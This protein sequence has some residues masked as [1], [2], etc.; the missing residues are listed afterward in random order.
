EPRD[1]EKYARELGLDMAKFKTEWESEA[2]ADRVS[3]DRKQGDALSLS[4]TP[5]IYINGR[6]FE[7][8]KFDMNE[9][10]ADWVTV[11][12]EAGPPS[13]TVAA[14]E[15]AAQ[16]SKTAPAASGSGKPADPPRASDKK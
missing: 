4:G 14:S 11:E 5:A 10:L 12:I 15:P 7:L 3:R 1:I 13:P 9:D 16:K 6:E 8:T 2:T